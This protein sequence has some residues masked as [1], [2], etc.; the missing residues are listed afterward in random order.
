MKGLW[1][2]RWKAALIWLC[3]YVNLIAYAVV[4]GFVVFR[5]EDQKLHRTEKTVFVV[6]LIF[7]AVEALLLILSNISSMTSGMGT[8]L[9]VIGLIETFA[10]IAVY[11]AGLISA[12]FAEDEEEEPLQAEEA[13]TDGTDETAE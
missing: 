6:T 3:G 1:T 9:S 4:G 7:T 12:L 5:T 11:A 13:E 10:K 2:H 8:A